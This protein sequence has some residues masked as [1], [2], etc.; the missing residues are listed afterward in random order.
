M[1]ARRA[2]ANTLSRLQGILKG[3]RNVNS[4]PDVFR[5]LSVMNKRLS[6]L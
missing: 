3:M 5:Y 2:V 4:E 1:T 6:L